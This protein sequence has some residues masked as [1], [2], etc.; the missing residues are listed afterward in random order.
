MAYLIISLKKWLDR[1]GYLISIIIAKLVKYRSSL[2]AEEG[3][4][5]RLLEYY[6]KTSC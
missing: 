3:C 5:N 1:I 2:K 4:I 6:Y